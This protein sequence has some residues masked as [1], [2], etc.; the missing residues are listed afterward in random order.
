MKIGIDIDGVL[1]DVCKYIIDEA[2][3]YYYL[4]GKKRIKNV[5][6]YYSTDIFEIQDDSDFWDGILFEYAINEPP[7]KYASEVIKKL[8]EEGNEIYIITAR[9]SDINLGEDVRER[10]KKVVEVWLEKHGIVYDKIIYSN[11]KLDSC[12]ENNVNIMIEDK[13]KNIL[14]IAT[15]IPVLCYDSYYNEDIKES[16]VYRVYSWYDIYAQIHELLDK[17]EL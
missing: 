2:S 14:S 3:R 11:K 5:K 13:P 16:N 4:N 1:T 17:G 7:R 15:T 10:M 9:I 8:K 12:I 6:A